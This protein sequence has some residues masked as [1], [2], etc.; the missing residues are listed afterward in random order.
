MTMP[1]SRQGAGTPDITAPAGERSDL[2]HERAAAAPGLEALIVDDDTG[3]REILAEYVRSRGVVVAVAGDGRAAIEAIRR[4]PAQFGLIFC[5]LSLPGAGGLDVLRAARAANASCLVVI[6]TGYASLDSAIQAVRLG[7]Y[8]YLTKP[9]ALGQIDVIL[10]RVQD[11]NALELENRRLLQRLEGSDPARG[12]PAPRHAGCVAAAPRSIASIS[13]W[14]ASSPPW[15]HFRD[16][17][18]LSDG[19]SHNC[20][21][22]GQAC[23]ISDMRPP[24]ARAPLQPFPWTFRPGA[25]LAELACGGPRTGI[26]NGPAPPSL[27]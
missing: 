18:P 3:V 12:L 11:R 17:C 8:D 4:R 9:F 5:D 1:S 20:R 26:A 22:T 27:L 24:A 14:H 23:R 13:G 7:A 2:Q 25:L 16:S 21:Q 10:R 6:I 15:R 19:R